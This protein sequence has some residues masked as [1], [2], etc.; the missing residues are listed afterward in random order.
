MAVPGRLNLPPLFFEPLVHPVQMILTKFLLLDLLGGRLI[1]P[2]PHLL[3]RMARAH[4]RVNY[5]WHL[6]W[7]VESWLVN[8]SSLSG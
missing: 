5:F 8:P 7:W 3:A 6:V 2:E 4:P 1:Q